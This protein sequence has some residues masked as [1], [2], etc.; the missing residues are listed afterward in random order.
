LIWMRVRICGSSVWG[1][2]F[3]VLDGNFKRDQTLF[4]V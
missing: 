1:F 3:S 2:S 4:V